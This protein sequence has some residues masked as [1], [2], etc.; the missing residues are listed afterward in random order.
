MA[1]GKQYLVRVGGYLQEVGTGDLTVS[2]EEPEPPLPAPECLTPGDTVVSQFVTT[3]LTLTGGLGCGDGAANL[4]ARSYPASMFGGPFDVSCVDFV[5]F[6]NTDSYIPSEIRLHRSATGNPNDGF[7]ETLGV[8]QFGL[9]GPAGYTLSSASFEAPVTVDLAEGEFLVVELLVN[10]QLGLGTAGYG[11]YCGVLLA[12]TDG[13]DGYISC[14]TNGGYFGTVSEIGFPDSQPYLVLNGSAGGA[15]CTGDFNDDGIVNG[16]DFG[17]I[18]AAWGPCAG[19][20]EDLNGDGQVTG[21][22][23]GLLLSV[24]GVCP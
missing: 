9:Y 20:P 19:C 5:W 2:W 1:S 18:L 16:A 7:I 12:D 15:S 8:N 6:A 4:T 10:R 17:S 13:T 23:V 11:G 22:D 24:W 14:S 3:T 21:A